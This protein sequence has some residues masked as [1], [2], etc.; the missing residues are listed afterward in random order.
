[1]ISW[2]YIVDKMQVNIQ[3]IEHNVSNY[4]LLRVKIL[5]LVLLLLFYYYYDSAV[6][7]DIHLWVYELLMS[8]KTW[9]TG[10]VPRTSQS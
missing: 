7:Y 5:V 4:Y 6:K 3:G 9:A 10:E 2:R 8:L 1:M